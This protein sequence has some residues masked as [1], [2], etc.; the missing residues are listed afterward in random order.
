[1]WQQW[2]TKNIKKYAISWKTHA[3]DTKWYMNALL[4]MLQFIKFLDY[5]SW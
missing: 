2:L 1:M 5:G 3:L 4:D